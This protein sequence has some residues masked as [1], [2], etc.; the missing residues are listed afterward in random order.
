MARSSTVISRSTVPV[1]L[2]NSAGGVP[3]VGRNSGGSVV[4]VVSGTVVVVV[5]VVVVEVVVVDVVVSG[6]A[7][8]VV[9][10]DPFP[11]HA[12]KSTARAVREIV[13]VRIAVFLGSGSTIGGGSGNH[14]RDSA[15]SV[16]ERPVVPDQPVV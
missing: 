5:V 13:F 16:G 2:S 15:F 9:S 6:A 12:A 14:E 4:V 8:V 10:A 3:G 7:V 11:E 1:K